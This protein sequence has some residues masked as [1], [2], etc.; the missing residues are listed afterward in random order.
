MVMVYVDDLLLIGEDDRVKHFLN[1]LEKQLQ[2]KH[3]TKLHADQALVFPR[4]FRGR[5]VEYY[6]GH[7]ALS[8]TKD[9]YNSLL[10][11]RNI[12]NHTKRP[13]IVT[14]EYLTPEEH[15]KYRTI[16]EKLLWVRPLRPD[17]QYATKKLTRAVQKPDQ[18]DQRNAKHLLRY[19][20]GTKRSN[21]LYKLQSTTP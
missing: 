17:T 1:R 8:M 4:L 6:G 7:I 14:N 18:L 11:L 16:V 3:V 19:L 20:H 15:S 2:L 13:P 21:N 12:R 10:L 5:Q 9:Y